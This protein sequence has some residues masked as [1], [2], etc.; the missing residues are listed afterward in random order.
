MSAADYD[1][2]GL[3]DLYFSGISSGAEKPALPQF[4]RAHFRAMTAAEVGPI[5]GTWAPLAGATWA[6]YDDDGWVDLLREIRA[7]AVLP[8]R[9]HRP[10]RV[11]DEPITLSQLALRRCLGR[12]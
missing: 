8:Q 10:V 6:D 4:R 12:L 1:H 11:G 2:D 5:V 7:L 3:L 9:W